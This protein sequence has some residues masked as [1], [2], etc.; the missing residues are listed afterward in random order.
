M[1]PKI[2]NRSNGNAGVAARAPPPV[3]SG[4]APAVIIAA[5]LGEYSLLIMPFIV[6]AMMQGYGLSE[7]NAGNF[8]SIQLVA[9]GVAGIAVSY[10]LARVPAHKIAIGS[11]FAIILAN[12]CCALGGGTLQLLAAR[13]CTGF[14]E[15]SLMAAA[16]ALAAR[17]NNPHRLFSALG[18]VI[19]IVAAAALL[20]TPLLIDRLGV[21]GVFWLLSASPIAV[22]L[23]ARWLP[24][25]K[26]E[27]IDAPRLGAL[28]VTGARAALS[29]FALLWIGASALWVF[30]E[31]IGTSQGLSLAEVGRYLAIG[32]IAGVMGP[33]VAARYAERTGLRS[34]LAAGSAVM[35]GA[36]LWMV[37]G[38]TPVSYVIAVSLI[39]IAVMFL[40]PCFRSL[41]A[42]LDGTGAVVAMSVA[43]YT[44]GFAAAPALVGALEMGGSN[45]HGVAW[46]AASAF[47]ASGVLGL[48]VRLPRPV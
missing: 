36:G 38:A 39:S 25:A 43:F 16:G 29:G 42:R 45:Y 27:R 21:R 30:A 5:L 18:F 34:S 13:A 11:A 14:A 10:V 37:Y 8:V 2:V 31:R 28:A 19:A 12:A 4:G 23:S 1:E 35:A 47:V 32:Q 41:M 26:T 22:L 17:V 46:L 6:V 44:F 48:T 3:R 40:V 9:M 15:G 7:V 33:L 24:R 20:L